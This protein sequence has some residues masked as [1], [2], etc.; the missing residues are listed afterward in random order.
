MVTHSSSK[1]FGIDSNALHENTS[2]ENITKFTYLKGLLRGK[3]LASIAG[4][5]LTAANYE[6]AVQILKSQYGNTQILIAVHI[7]K[8][9]SIT[10]VT[11]SENIKELRSLYD[12][13]EVHIRNL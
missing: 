2:V 5:S 9:M 1:V 4:L 10:P 7:D 13:I 12:T 8:L 3:A 6:E 11:S